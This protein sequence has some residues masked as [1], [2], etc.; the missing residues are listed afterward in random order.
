MG[1]AKPLGGALKKVVE[2]LCSPEREERVRL[3]AKWEQM[4]GAKLAQL[5][6]P[7]FRGLG[8]VVWVTNAPLAYE[9]SQRYGG[10]ILKRLQNE[11][12][13]ERVGKVWFC[14]GEPR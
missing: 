9:V 2:D 8:V 11:F 14:V 12:G 1:D 10:V 7:R 4:V 3:C 6:T 13:E 5:T